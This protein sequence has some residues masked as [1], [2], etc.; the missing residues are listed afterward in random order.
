M[1]V[2]GCAGTQYGCCPGSTTAASGPNGEGC[3]SGAGATT[4]TDEG[5]PPPPPETFGAYQKKGEANQGV[6]SMI[7]LLVRDLDKEKTEASTE[8]NDA[9]KDY[10]EMMNDS[11]KK[12]AADTK[13]M[14]AKEAAKAEAEEGKVADEESKMNEFKQLTATKQF[15]KQ[16]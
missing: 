6:L 1:T 4:K 16:L 9:Q 5:A 11:A 7:D 10:E 15:E 2:G 8:E 3:E 13:S 14:A 12:R